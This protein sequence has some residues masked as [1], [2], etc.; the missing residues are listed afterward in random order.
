MT[1]WDED[2]GNVFV[3]TYLAQLLPLQLPELLQRVVAWEKQ[4]SQFSLQIS[5][6]AGRAHALPLYRLRANM[7]ALIW[8]QKVTF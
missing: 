1:A 4:N 6:V 8:M 7:C 2:N 5:V 3:H